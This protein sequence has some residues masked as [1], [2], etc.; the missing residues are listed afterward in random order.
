[1]SYC[2]RIIK[3][4]DSRCVAHQLILQRHNN[5]NNNK[6]LH[7]QKSSDSP[8]SPESLVSVYDS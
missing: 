7:V 2:K 8:G 5:N 3:S 4:Y 6:P 1:M